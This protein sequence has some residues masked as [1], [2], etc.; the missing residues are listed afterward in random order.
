[1]PVTF[2]VLAITLICLGVYLLRHGVRKRSIPPLPLALALCS[3]LTGAATLYFKN[4]LYC[5][6]GGVFV[7]CGPFIATKTK[8]G[9]TW[10]GKKARRKR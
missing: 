4:P 2:Y 10:G 7:C 9:R 3:I 6:F 5:V 8:I 1:M